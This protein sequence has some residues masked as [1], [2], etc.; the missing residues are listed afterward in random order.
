MFN[1]RFLRIYGLTLL[2]LL[3]VSILVFQLMER[4]LNANLET[5]L[6][7]ESNVLIN[8]L[9]LVTGRDE[10]QYAAIGRPARL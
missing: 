4:S 2:L 9:L 6:K 10:S 8:L 1:I 7:L 5:D 3:T